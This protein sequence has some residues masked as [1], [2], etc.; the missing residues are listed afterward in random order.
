MQKNKWSLA[1]ISAV[2][3]LLVA[4]LAS[5]QQSSRRI[6]PGTRITVRVQEALQSGKTTE[7]SN[8]NGTMVN[9]ITDSRGRVVAQAGSPVSGVVRESK[10]SGRLKAP[11]IL[12]LQ[13]TTVNNVPVNADS[14]TRDGEGH[15]KSNVTKVGGGTAAGAVIGGLAGGGKGAGIGALAGAGAGAIGAFATGKR[16]AKIPAETALTFTAQ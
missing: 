1:R 3:F 5:A 15:T 13:L 8:W 11:G 10:D 2:L 7:G 4:S 6:P 9:E 16:Q 14:I 12:T